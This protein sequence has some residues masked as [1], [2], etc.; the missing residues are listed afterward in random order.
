MMNLLWSCCPYI[1]V[2]NK[3]R[4]MI[5][6]E[7]E[8]REGEVTRPLFHLTDEQINVLKE[9]KDTQVPF[10]SLENTK[11]TGY[12]LDCYDGDTMTLGFYFG[13]HI[14]KYKC[15]MNRYDAPEMKPKNTESEELKM[16]EKKLAEKSKVELSRL[17]LN[18][19]VYIQSA[20]YDLYGRLLVDVYMSEDFTNATQSINDMMIKARYGY[21]Y[22]GEKKKKFS[23]LL[24]Y[25]REHLE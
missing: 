8:G 4:E 22:N 13:D 20:K 18:K 17:I 6:G 3:D 9:K 21:P 14:Y 1:N 25:Y 23:E 15:R 12:V 24:E 19:V 7:G 11:I 5:Y 10:L 2:N 16:L